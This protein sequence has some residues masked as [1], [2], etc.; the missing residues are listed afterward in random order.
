MN[1]ILT[2]STNGNTKHGIFREL[3]SYNSS[4]PSNPYFEISSSEPEPEHLYEYLFD[5]SAS[6]HFGSKDTS[7]FLLFDF[8]TNR[9]SLKNFYIHGVQNPYT[10]S[11][12]ILGSNDCQSWTVI[13][14]YQSLDERLHNKME[15]FNLTKSSLFF[16]YLKYVNTESTLLNGEKNY[17]T[18][19]MFAFDIFGVLCPFRYLHILTCKW[20]N[21]SI[22]PMRILIII[23]L[24]N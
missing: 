1:D 8:K 21:I 16:R 13:E 22:K 15:T 23:I 6:S 12:D 24:K 11:F 19:G 20:N 5:E 2:I 17:D 18:F 9:I 4:L 14:R 7:L 10:T 3:L